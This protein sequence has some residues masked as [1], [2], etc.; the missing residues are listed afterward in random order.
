MIFLLSQMDNENPQDENEDNNYT[1]IVRVTDMVYHPH[2]MSKYLI[3]LD[4][5]DLLLATI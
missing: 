4:G 1:L 2:M 5:W 3:I